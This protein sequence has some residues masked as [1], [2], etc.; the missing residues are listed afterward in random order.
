MIELTPVVEGKFSLNSSQSE[1]LAKRFGSR[2]PEFISFED[3]GD[4]LEKNELS[5]KNKALENFQDQLGEGKLER[6]LS[7]RNAEE[8]LRILSKCVQTNMVQYNSTVAL[9]STSKDVI[10]N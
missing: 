7:E 10:E 9:N 5:Y 3:P 6:L 4:A 1:T 8:A 2:F